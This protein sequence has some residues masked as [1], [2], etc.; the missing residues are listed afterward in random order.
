MH[1]VKRKKPVRPQVVISK[2]P[3]QLHA[4]TR[5]RDPSTTTLR[6]NK[7]APTTT[8]FK[9]DKPDADEQ[10]NP[11][12]DV[13]EFGYLYT[14]ALQM[15]QRVTLPHYPPIPRTEQAREMGE[16]LEDTEQYEV[17]VAPATNPAYK[18]VPHTTTKLGG[19]YDQVA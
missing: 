16:S 17:M 19:I 1:R 14:S 4:S 15:S 3:S 18:N 13:D 9:D 8:T 2:L 6:S 11:L 7:E 5:R 12:D 10:D